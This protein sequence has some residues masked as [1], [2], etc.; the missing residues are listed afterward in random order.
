[1]NSPNFKLPIPDLL[2]KINP[3]AVDG[4]RLMPSHWNLYDRLKKLAGKNGL[5]MG[6]KAPKTP[7]IIYDELFSTGI[8]TQEPSTYEEWRELSSAATEPQAASPAPTPAPAPAPS[9][10]PSEKPA[11]E[12]PAQALAAK[13]APAPVPSPAPAP[14]P[15]PKPVAVAPA[16]TAAST[17]DASIEIEDL[18]AS[19]FEKGASGFVES[20]TTDLDDELVISVSESSDSSTEV[21][22]DFL[23]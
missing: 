1:M 15:A 8:L 18:E 21:D 6:S 19:T 14:S 16:P 12:P 4:V 2:L 13:P 22:L 20:S 3:D 9:P 7:D 10:Q 23:D 5:I 11:A 17:Q